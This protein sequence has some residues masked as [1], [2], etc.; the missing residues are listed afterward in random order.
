MTLIEILKENRLMQ[1]ERE[2]AKFENALA[3]IANNPNQEDL[4]EYHLILDDKCQQPEVMFALVHFLESFELETQLMAFL[5]VIP[6]LATIAPEWTKILHN[7]IL[8]DET[9]CNA[10]LKIL[11]SL[12]S[13]KPHFLYY[14]L[15]ESA[16]NN[17]N[18]KIV[19]C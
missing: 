7:R 17:L 13:E 12:N 19:N 16:A 14:L 5:K 3:E 1:T 10:Y 2:V 18:R 4:P 6:Q 15:E 8:N 11:R 9:A